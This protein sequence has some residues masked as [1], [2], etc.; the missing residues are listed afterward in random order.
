MPKDVPEL[1][2]AR[3]R[4]RCV[5]SAL[6]SALRTG[7]ASRR[8]NRRAPHAQDE[9][10]RIAGI[11]KAARLSCCQTQYRSRC[12]AGGTHI[13]R[14]NPSQKARRRRS[15]VSV[16]AAR[17]RCERDLRASIDCGDGRQR[18]VILSHPRQRTG[19]GSPLCARSTSWIARPKRPTT[20]SR[21]WRRKSA[22]ARSAT[23]A[24]STTIAVGSRRNMAF[25][26]R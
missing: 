16:D 19:S 15:D 25:R 3:R 11:S 13:E 23:S 26:R 10:R 14:F 12:R 2:I 9:R 24:S 18:R 8:D 1:S 20:K 4:R 6:H 22:N 7:F 17:S 21:S 5:G